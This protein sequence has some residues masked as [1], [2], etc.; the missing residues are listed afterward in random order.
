MFLGTLAGLYQSHNL[1]SKWVPL[2]AERGCVTGVWVQFV[3]WFASACFLTTNYNSASDLSHSRDSQ[4]A[5]LPD[6]A[7]AVCTRP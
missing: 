6:S 1:N 3:F 2:K 4:P 7:M 5:V